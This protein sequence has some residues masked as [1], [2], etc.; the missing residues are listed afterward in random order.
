MVSTN[1]RV[2]LR[3]TFFWESVRPKAKWPRFQTLVRKDSLCPTGLGRKV[4]MS[5]ELNFSSE[6]STRCQSRIPSRVPSR[7]ESTLANY[8]NSPNF[9][10]SN[11][12]DRHSLTRVATNLTKFCIIE[13][14]KFRA[15]SFFEGLFTLFLL[16]R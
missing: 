13:N 1:F 8:Q 10:K 16:N 3:L 4:S 14:L 12:S 5:S 9:E 7:R 15:L 2:I 6:L 11:S